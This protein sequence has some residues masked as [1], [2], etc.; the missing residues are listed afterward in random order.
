VLVRLGVRRDRLAVVLAS[1]AGAETAYREALYWTGTPVVRLAYGLDTHSDSLLVGSAVALWLS[2]GGLLRI[3]RPVLRAGAWASL[4]CL[5]VLAETGNGD[6]SFQWG[7]PLAAAATATLIAALVT[8]SSPSLDRL[9]SSRA[10]VWT[11]RRSYGLYL[12][13]LPIYYG[14]PWPARFTGPARDA[15]EIAVSFVFAA[16]SYRVVELPFLRRKGR[17]H[18]LQP[19]RPAGSP[20][21]DQRPAGGP[22]EAG[23][24]I[25]GS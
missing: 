1:A 13:S 20:L 23:R 19:A 16:V 6:F 18:R 2:T 15:S 5:A 8:S 24:T 21:P 7:Y 11:G 17:L 4:A 3:P 9:L 12:W 22:V 10:A 14:L 25:V